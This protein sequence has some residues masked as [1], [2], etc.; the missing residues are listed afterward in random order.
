MAIE[1]CMFLPEHLYREVMTES[2]DSKL[3]SVDGFTPNDMYLD[4]IMEMYPRELT[5]RVKMS[6]PIQDEIQKRAVD[7]A[8]SGQKIQ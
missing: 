4:Q 7:L 8:I 1:A 3:E 5:E 2:P 6:P